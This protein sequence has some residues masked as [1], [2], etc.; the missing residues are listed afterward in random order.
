M[1]LSRFGWIILFVIV[2]FGL[3][4]L[5]HKIWAGKNNKNSHEV[6]NEKQTQDVKSSREERRA[7]YTAPPLV[8][9]EVTSRGSRE[10]LTCHK[11][12]FEVGVGAGKNLESLKQKGFVVKGLDISK[13]AAD[14]ARKKNL[15]IVDYHII[16]DIYICHGHKIPEKIDQKTHQRYNL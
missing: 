16:N 2:L 6:Q 11:K 9:H 10:C 5:P 7:F 4:F 8:P 1:K 13:T 14:F 12:V 3:V 15:E